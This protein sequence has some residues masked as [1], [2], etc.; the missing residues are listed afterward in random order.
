MEKSAADNPVRASMTDMS[1]EDLPTGRSRELDLSDHTYG[2][3][4]IDLITMEADR[5]AGCFTMMLCDDRNRGRQPICLNELRH[6]APVN[7][8]VNV[9]SLVLPVLAESGGSILMARG[10]I[11]PLRATDEDRVW[12]QRAIELCREYGVRLLGFH[13]ATPQGVHR[14]PDPLVAVDVA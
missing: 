7:D 6:E 4:L 3:D 10:R 12:H 14:L 2:A 9:L 5:R 11:G 8:M 13:V 1:F